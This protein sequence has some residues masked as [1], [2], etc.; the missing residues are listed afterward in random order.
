VVAPGD[1]RALADAIRRVLT[2]DSLRSTLAA[3]AAVRAE[4]LFGR[5]RMVDAFRRVVE[6]IAGVE[7]RPHPALAQVQPS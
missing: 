2:D 1:R 4:T 3:N 6:G 5:S 7:R